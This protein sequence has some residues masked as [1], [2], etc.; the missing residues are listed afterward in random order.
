MSQGVIP[1]AHPELW[2]CST[3]PK[4]HNRKTVRSGASVSLLLPQWG[5]G[6]IIHVKIWRQVHGVG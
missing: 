3:I 5:S 1:E 4:H 6:R 2:D